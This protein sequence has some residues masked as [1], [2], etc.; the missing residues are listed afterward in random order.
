MDD[1]GRNHYRLRQA[2]RHFG[3]T[4]DKVSESDQLAYMVSEMKKRNPASY[5]VFMNPNATEGE[6]QRA[7]YAYWGY[8]HEGARFTYARNLL[9]QGRL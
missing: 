4:I 3:K 9:S 7:S 1:A 5:R 6:L 2:E 8:G